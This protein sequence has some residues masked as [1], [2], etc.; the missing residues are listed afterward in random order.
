MN[1]TITLYAL[2][3]YCDMSIISL[4]NWKKCEVDLYQDI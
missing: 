3:L 2:N 1:Q 4:Y